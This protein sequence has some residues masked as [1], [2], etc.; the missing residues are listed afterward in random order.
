M[1]SM[2]Q[3]VIHEL[4]K[5]INGEKRVPVKIGTSQLFGNLQHVQIFL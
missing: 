5:N 1:L 2:V 4:I 3:E